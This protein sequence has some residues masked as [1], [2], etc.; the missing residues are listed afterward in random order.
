M[1]NKPS[2]MQ[3]FDRQTFIEPKRAQSPSRSRAKALPIDARNGCRMIQGQVV[4]SHARP[5]SMIRNL[6][7]IIIN[8]KVRPASSRR[9]A[10]AA[11]EMC[12]AE[13][14]LEPR[15]PGLGLLEAHDSVDPSAKKRPCFGMVLALVVKKYGEGG[16]ID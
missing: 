11:N 1:G 8:I 12:G 6:R 3:G 14:Q 15:N 7:A 2:I 16:G 4:K 13:R 5:V 10:E 9:V